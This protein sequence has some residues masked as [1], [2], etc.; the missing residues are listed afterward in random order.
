MTKIGGVEPAPTGFRAR[1]RAALTGSTARTAGWLTAWKLAKMA[2]ALFVGIW[3]ARHLGPE[4]YGVYA[5][6]MALMVVMTPLASFGLASAVTKD[7]T[8][9]PGKIA[10]I[11]GTTAVLRLFGGAL[12]AAIMVA[13]ASF[14]TLNAENLPLMAGVVAL[15]GIVGFG[16]LLEYLFVAKQVVKPF[17]LLSISVIGLT[18]LAKAAIML[19]GGGIEPLIAASSAEFAAAGGAGVIAYWIWGGRLRD[20]RVNLARA[21]LY[22]RRG[23]PLIA[24][25]FT[26]AIYLKI[27]V[28]FLAEIRSAEEAGMY[29]VAARLSEIWFLLPP[30]LMSAAFPRLLQLRRDAPGLYQRRLQLMFDGLAAAA[31]GV[32]VVMTLAAGPVVALLFGPAFAPAAA[33][34][35][36]HVWSSLFS[37]PRA[38]VSKWFVAEDLYTLALLN[39]AFGALLNV[40]LNLILIPP[41]GAMGAAVATLISYAAAT[42]GALALSRPGRPVAIMIVKALFWP[43]RLPDLLRLMRVRR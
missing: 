34:L 6:V 16:A 31:T 42:V 32:A 36:V 39:N 1:L 40:V 35:M 33:I 15:G 24:S 25:G 41:Y 22:L 17:V 14:S 26:A 23:V 4:D 29:A 38:L 19:A 13:I 43:R 18:A 9:E 5:Y 8:L 37:F 30:I 2:S 27:D 12:V 11:L 7:I 28:I 20:W 3:I 21:R 10:E